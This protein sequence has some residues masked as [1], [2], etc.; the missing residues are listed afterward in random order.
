[1]YYCLFVTAQLKEERK[2]LKQTNKQKKNTLAAMPPSLASG[3]RCLSET[4][5][6]S[7][8]AP[9]T[10]TAPCA[11]SRA[12]RAGAVARFPR[13]PQAARRVSGVTRRQRSPGSR[14]TEPEP[15]R[16]TGE[17]GQLAKCRGERLRALCPCAGIPRASGKLPS[18]ALTVALNCCLNIL[19][20]I[21]SRF[22]R[23]GDG[24]LGYSPVA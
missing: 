5:K 6:T 18:P 8:H 24:G 15:W 23:W 17:R 13:Q 3:D 14:T 4:P 9:G 21:H 20:G 1:M 16:E 7:L 2:K 12:P 11:G 22:S 10:G 19:L